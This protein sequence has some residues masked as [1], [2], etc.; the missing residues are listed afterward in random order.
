MKNIT[1][2]FGLIVLLAILIFLGA[3]VI[4]FIYIIFFAY[5]IWVIIP[6]K[7]KKNGERK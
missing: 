3:F 6:K 1:E 5:L 7:S 4:A 2:I